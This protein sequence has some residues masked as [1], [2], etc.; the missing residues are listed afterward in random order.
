[1]EKTIVVSGCGVSAVCNTEEGVLYWIR[2]IIDRGG[3]PLVKLWTAT[4]LAL[5]IVGPARAAAP[6][7]M[8]TYADNAIL[9]AAQHGHRGVTLVFGRAGLT[10]VEAVA[11]ELRQRGYVLDEQ[12]S[13][14]NP[15]VIKVLRLK[16]VSR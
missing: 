6:L 4:L 8:L 13:E 5:L 7:D 16:A 9:N 1:M 15:E 12:T 10:E 14:L 2:E 3:V 11:A